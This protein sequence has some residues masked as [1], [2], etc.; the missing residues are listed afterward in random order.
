MPKQI[1]KQFSLKNLMSVTHEWLDLNYTKNASP[2]HQKE[3]LPKQEKENIEKI[4]WIANS[5]W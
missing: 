5:N 4:Q 2:N 3:K 1:S